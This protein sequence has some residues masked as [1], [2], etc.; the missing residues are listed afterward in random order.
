MSDDAR[1]EIIRAIATL[2]VIGVLFAMTSVQVRDG[3]RRWWT[4]ASE[5]VDGP[6]APEPSHRD[7]S[8]V[9][10]RADEITRGEA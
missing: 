7:I 4:R 10:R 9:L 5:A 6:A 2:V 1:N 3:I 8:E